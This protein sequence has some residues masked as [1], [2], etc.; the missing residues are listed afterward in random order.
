VSV[1]QCK[2]GSRC[3]QLWK[4]ANKFDLLSLQFDDAK[5]KRYFSTCFFLLT[6]GDSLKMN[7]SAYEK[8]KKLK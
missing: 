7:K 1:A 6:G 4:V 5:Y 3:Q 8:K 2:T